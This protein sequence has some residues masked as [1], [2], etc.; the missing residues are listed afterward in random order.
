MTGQASTRPFP[1][2]SVNRSDHAI[3]LLNAHGL[4]V[5]G[6]KYTKAQAKED[7]ETIVLGLT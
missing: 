5:H 4:K 1:H 2:P 6:V 7:G 3:A